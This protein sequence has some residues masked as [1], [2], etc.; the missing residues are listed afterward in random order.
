MDPKLSFCGIG[1]AAR[2]GHHSGHPHRGYREGQGYCVQPQRPAEEAGQPP[3]GDQ[4]AGDGAGAAHSGQGEGAPRPGMCRYFF[5]RA[6]DLHSFFADPD[7][8]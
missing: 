6:V 7:L 2:A 3:G 5:T 4:A 8:A 1:A